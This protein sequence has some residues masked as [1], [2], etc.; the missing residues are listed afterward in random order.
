MLFILV[1]PRTHFDISNAQIHHVK[2]VG[3]ITDGYDITYIRLNS[4]QNLFAMVGSSRNMAFSRSV[5]AE[6]V[7]SRTTL[8]LL[9]MVLYACDLGVG[10]WLGKSM[11][12]ELSASTFF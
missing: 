4:S 3:C 11:I 7:K 9:W 8:Y 12:C 6:Y 1:V 2:K 10:I 5:T